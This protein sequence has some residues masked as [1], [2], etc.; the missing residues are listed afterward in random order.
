ML[1]ALGQHRVSGGRNKVINAVSTVKYTTV[2]IFTA[3]FLAGPASYAW[4]SLRYRACDVSLELPA[5]VTCW[6]LSAGVPLV[7]YGQ[8]TS[9]EWR[10][11]LLQ[12]NRSGQITVTAI[13][14][15]TPD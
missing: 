14:A 12:Q 8:Q 3:S 2:V 5:G 6:A 1:S 13:Q 4:P 11:A 10:R 9:I 15:S 7:F